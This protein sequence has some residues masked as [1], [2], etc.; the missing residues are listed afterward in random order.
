MK[1]TLINV[2]PDALETL[3]FTKN[4]RLR[5]SALGIE[6]VKAW[7]PEQKQAELDYMRDTIQ[8]GWEFVD[9]VFV[10]EE[11]TR[12]FTHQLVRHRVGTSF[13]QQA[14]RAVDM[15]GFTYETGPSIT[16][17][18]VSDYPGR[19]GFN[20]AKGVYDETMEY[21][22]QGYQSLV[23][24]GVKGQDA[25]GV[26]PTNIHT[27]IVFKANLRTLHDMALKRLCVKAQG[28]FQEVFRALVAEVVR[29]HPWAAAFLRVQCAWNG[30]CL[31]PRLPVEEC[32]VKPFVY[33]HR[34]GQA[35]GHDRTWPVPG[36]P[37]REL[38]VLRPEPSETIY[39]LHRATHV[40]DIQPT[41]A[42]QF[43]VPLVPVDV[44]IREEPPRENRSADVEA[45][46]AVASPMECAGARY[47]GQLCSE[48]AAP[49]SGRCYNCGRE[50]TP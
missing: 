16:E 21:I 15:S 43:G 17:Y 23:A 41:V 28:E 7:T 26:L 34:T 44:G 4:T 46:V 45:A 27:N 1:V 42:G 9:Y 12:A 25:R 36:A 30:T 50:I 13:A 24:M 37:G 33:D 14:Q 29:V 18:P 19:E 48:G 49:G 6:E 5:M 3:I 40:R 22:N 2:T 39:Q 38:R 32:E 20:Q 8:S 11:V 35:Y 47:N 10:I 31:F